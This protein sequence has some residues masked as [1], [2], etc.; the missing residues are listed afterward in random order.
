MY[1]YCGIFS[2]LYMYIYNFDIIGDGVIS[3]FDFI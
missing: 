2:G 1:M 3:D